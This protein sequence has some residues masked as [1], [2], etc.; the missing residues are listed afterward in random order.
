MQLYEF[1]S[2]L[3]T[4]TGYFKFTINYSRK[5][6][7]LL[8]VELF[9]KVDGFGSKI[10]QKPMYGNALLHYIGHPQWQKKA[11]IKEQMVHLC[12][13]VSEDNIFLDE[14]DNMV[15]MFLTRKYPGMSVHEMANYVIC[16]RNTIFGPLLGGDED[17]ALNDGDKVSWHD[18]M[19]LTYFNGVKQFTNINK[20]WDIIR[21]TRQLVSTLATT[22][23]LH[24]KGDPI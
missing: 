17:S 11:L 7:N 4:V 15:T 20:N 22:P 16:N 23:V 6:M 1:H 13:L 24:I 10:Y 8:D 2:Y 14:R 9:K 5:N 12:R 18:N 19:I 21:M 3:N